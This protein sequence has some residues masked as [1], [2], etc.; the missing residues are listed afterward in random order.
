MKAVLLAAGLGTR[1]RPLTDSVP[2]AMVP[3][4]GKPML[5]HHIELLKR[6][7]A[8]EFFINLH[9]LPEV[10]TSRIGDGARWGVR[11]NYIHEPSLLGTAGTVRGLAPQLRDERFWVYYADNFT[12]AN[13]GRLTEFHVERK[14][15][16]TIAV[17]YREDV[18]TSGVVLFDREGRVQQFVEKPQGAVP[19]HLVNAGIYVCEPVI[20]ELI[21]DQVPC[22]FARDVFPRLLREGRELHAL[23]LDNWLIGVDTVEA[24]ERVNAMD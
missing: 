12:R 18:Q 7:G 4:K 8:T 24:L 2:K 6:Y 3:V 19:G 11:I 20:L 21:P 1:L 10:V 16:V 9:H 17:H 15:L 5:E 23:E 14:A 13:L 22:D